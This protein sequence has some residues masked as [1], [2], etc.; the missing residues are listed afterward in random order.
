MKHPIYMILGDSPPGP[1][2]LHKEYD[3]FMKIPLSIFPIESVSYT[4]PDSMYKVPLDQLDR[5]Y[6]E[7]DPAPAVYLLH[8]I[9][10]VIERYEVYK[11]NNHA[12]EAQ[13]WD[14]EPLG[15]YDKENSGKE[16]K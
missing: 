4:Y 7:R 15:K 16:A 1:H 10:G 8:E 14:L 2:D 5:V 9:P 13:V 6:L 11:H 12:I 3:Y